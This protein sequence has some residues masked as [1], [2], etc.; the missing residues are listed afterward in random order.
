V[1]RRVLVGAAAA[2]GAAAVVFWP[3]I[4]ARR[5]AAADPLRGYPAAGPDAIRAFFTSYCTDCHGPD[6]RKADR[7][8]DRL[9]LPANDADTLALLQDALDQL[10][11]G[12]MPPA[13]AKQ[14]PADQ[15]RAAI[16]ALTRAVADGRARVASTGGRAVLRRL[17]RREYLNTVGD[18]FALNMTMFDP[19]T[20]FPRDETAAHLDTVGDALKTSG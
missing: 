5:A 9:A 18:L 10:N 6:K 3:S 11:L 20:K 2:L 16:D 8:F 7:R 1:N 13:K 15:R 14:P 12:D 4:A 17:N 19:T